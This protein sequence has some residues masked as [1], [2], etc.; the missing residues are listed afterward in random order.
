[1]ATIKAERTPRPAT[2][3]AWKIKTVVIPDGARRSSEDC[4]TQGDAYTRKTCAPLLELRKELAEAEEL[5]RL[6]RGR[7]NYANR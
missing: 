2:V 4:T 6:E 7:R 1:M 3:V 5:E